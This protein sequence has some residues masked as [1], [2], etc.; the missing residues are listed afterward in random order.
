MTQPPLRSIVIV[1]ATS[2]IA[3]HCARAWLEERATK[4]V[5]IGRDGPR[6]G[7]VAADLSVRSPG[8]QVQ[9]ISGDL[10]APAFIQATIEQIAVQGGLDIGLV[11]HG[12]LPD[13]SACQQDLYLCEQA[14]QINA[15]SPVLWAQALAQ[16]LE[17]QGSG[18]LIVIGSVAGDRGRKSNYIYGAAKG[19]VERCTQGLQHRFAHTNV[20]VVLIKPGPTDTPMTAALKQNGARLASVA[21]VARAIVRGTAQEGRPVIYAPGLWRWIMLVIR[22]LPRALFHRMNI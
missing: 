5:L 7:R 4:L 10:L 12:L 16:Q 9:V 19:L 8:S 6:L 3:E 20:R 22:H 17:R 2:A 13:Q 21:A 1:G 14:L 11:A 15:I 18:T